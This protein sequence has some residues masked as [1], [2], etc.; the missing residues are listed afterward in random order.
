MHACKTKTTTNK[1]KM[2]KN[3]CG[4]IMGKSKQVAKCAPSCSTVQFGGKDKPWTSMA[5]AF[6][7]QQHMF[8]SFKTKSQ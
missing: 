5:G 4:G 8:V 3:Y 7:E 2:T 1:S 6:V